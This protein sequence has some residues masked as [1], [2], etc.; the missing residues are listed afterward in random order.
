MSIDKKCLSP[1]IVNRAIIL[2]TSKPDEGYLEYLKRLSIQAIL[3]TNN[4][5]IAQNCINTSG[6]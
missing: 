5:L 4:T 1:S 2:V 6:N 3:D